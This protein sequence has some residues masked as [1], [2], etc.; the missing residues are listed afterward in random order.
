MVVGNAFE[1]VDG[2]CDD[3][4]RPLSEDM[5]NDA[6]EN[7]FCTRRV[8][9]GAIPFLFPP[10]QDA[11]SLVARLQANDWWGEIVG[12]HGSGKSALLATLIPHI[13]L[14]GKRPMLVELHDGQRRLPFRMNR[15]DR[16][17]SSAVLIIDGYEQLSRWSRFLLKRHCRRRGI[18]LVVT[19]HVSVG[20]PE[21]YRTE[22]TPELAKRLVA[23]LV[24]SALPCSEADVAASF[25]RHCGDVRE[26]L[27]EMYDLYEQCRSSALG[28][29]DF[30]ND[31]LQ[32]ARTPK[33]HT[34]LTQS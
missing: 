9:P 21:L 29:P 19:A 5:S 34:P 13:E 25:T 10:G 28:S 20:L 22:P 32:T 2:L 26:M 17:Q 3:H 16:F 6:S 30:L 15:D 11:E 14:A 4:L 7:P 33:A 8:R 23:Q 24:P 18:G 12:R 27:F 31:A 1:C